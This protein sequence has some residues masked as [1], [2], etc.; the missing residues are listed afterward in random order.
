[1]PAGPLKI[2][3]YAIAKEE[4]RHVARFVDGARDADLIVVA[5]TGSTDGTVEALRRAGAEVHSI[6]VSPWRFDDAR[7]AALALTPA[8]A[9]VCVS[10]DLDEVLQPGWRAALEQAWTA[11]ATR[12]RYRF[13]AS[14][15]ADGS[16]GL[17]FWNERIHARSGYRWRMPIHEVLLWC[18]AGEERRR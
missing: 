18:G 4:I 5:D 8:D 1:M 13:V 7:N 6:F 17:T 15:N 14:W 2:V 10:L 9:D 16:P 3:V 11:K 12:A